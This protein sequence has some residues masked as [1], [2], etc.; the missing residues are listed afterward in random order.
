MRQVGSHPGTSSMATLQ[1]KG[2]DDGLYRALG[3]RAALDNRSI[4]QEVVSIIREFLSRPGRDPREATRAL[5]ELSGS[6]QD[7]RSA[8]QIAA[9]LRKSRRTGRRFGK[10]RDVFA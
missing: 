6:W 4:S 3:A 5:L 1:V 9:D 10:G 7:E 8:Q 2:M